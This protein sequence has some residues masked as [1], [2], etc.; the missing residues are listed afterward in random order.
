MGEAWGEFSFLRP[1]GFNFLH[2]SIRLTVYYAVAM[3]GASLDKIAEKLH[4]TSISR[5]IFLCVGG[6]CASASVQQNNWEFLKGR[7]KALGLVD[8]EGGIFR[9]KAECLRI[10]ADGPVAVVYPEGAWYR[11][12][13][14]ENLERIIQ[15]HLIGGEVVQD[16]LIAVNPLSDPGALHE[17]EAQSDAPPD[18]P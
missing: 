15:S 18:T 5:H 13:S 8:V 3:P 16:L 17:P 7:L 10:C 14:P 2:S 4:L 9:S 12:C 11:Q 6:K 1:G